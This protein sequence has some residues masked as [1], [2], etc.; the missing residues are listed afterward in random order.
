MKSK[1]EKASVYVAV[2]EQDKVN[3]GLLA[4]LNQYTNF[5]SGVKSIDFEYLYNDK[6]CMA[7]STIQGSYIIKQYMGGEYM[8]EYQFKL[9]YRAQPGTKSDRLNMDEVLDTMA[10]MAVSRCNQKKDMPDIGPGLKVHRLIC[11][12]RSSFFGR[13]EGGDEDHQILMTLTYYSERRKR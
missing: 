1:Q 4:W 9:I 11:N 13:Y 2:A 3:R 12:T 6:P 5:P 8:A 10:D 7:L